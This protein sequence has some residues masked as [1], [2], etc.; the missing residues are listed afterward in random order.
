MT[1]QPVPVWRLGPRP[2]STLGPWELRMGCHRW[3]PESDFGRVL[4]EALTAEFWELGELD[5]EH[6]LQL[7]DAPQTAWVAEKKETG[8]SKSL[9]LSAA[10]LS[11]IRYSKGKCRQTRTE[12]SYTEMTYRDTLQQRDTKTSQRDFI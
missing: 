1:V 7:E 3:G 10:A 5:V 11:S 12:S 2:E 6:T 4:S 8:R 9:N